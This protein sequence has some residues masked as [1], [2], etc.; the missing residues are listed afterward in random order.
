MLILVACNGPKI[1][2][3]FNACLYFS[4]CT[5]AYTMNNVSHRYNCHRQSRPPFVCVMCLPSDCCPR[6]VSDRPSLSVSVFR[7]RYCRWRTVPP[8]GGGGGPPAAAD[9]PQLSEQLQLLLTENAALRSRLHKQ[10]QQL[11][12]PRGEQPATGAPISD[13]EKQLLRDHELRCSCSAPAS[14]TGDVS[15]LKG[16]GMVRGP[17]G[18][19]MAKP[20][21][22]NFIRSQ[23]CRY[24]LRDIMSQTAIVHQYFLPTIFFGQEVAARQR[25]RIF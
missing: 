14:I 9:P 19:G 25:W 7:T 8:G 5:I 22:H 1:N 15:R 6:C 23:H 10:Q 16:P 11:P 18:P 21:A 13:A 17:D 20:A 24:S 3:P 4:R 12:G 2:M